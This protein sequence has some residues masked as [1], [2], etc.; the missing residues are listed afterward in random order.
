MANSFRF[1]VPWP[2]LIFLGLLVVGSAAFTFAVAVRTRDHLYKI[3]KKNYLPFM[4]CSLEREIGDY[5]S[6]VEEA[7]EIRVVLRC[8][9]GG[10]CE[11][12]DGEGGVGEKAV[13]DVFGLIW[14]SAFWLI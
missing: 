8:T 11:V 12:K 2:I 4:F 14:L 10:W 6:I 7:R 13:G 1:Q 5:V 3:Y 9:R